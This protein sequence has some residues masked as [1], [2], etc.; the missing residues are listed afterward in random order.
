MRQKNIGNHKVVKGDLNLNNRRI[1]NGFEKQDNKVLNEFYQRNLPV[2]QRLV[3]ENSGVVE[4]AEDLMQ[5]AMMRL[6]QKIKSDVLELRCSIHTFFYGI[7]K[8]LWYNALRKNK[9]LVNFAELFENEQEEASSV[10]SILEKEDK[11]SVYQHHFSKLN[12]RSK[13][14]WELS[15]QGKSNKEIAK[16]LKCSEGS[17]RK[18]KFDAKNSLI[19]SLQKDKRYLE[20]I[21]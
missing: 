21:A 5:D 14:V 8:N 20:L 4:D 6:H 11:N 9:R 16:D 19:S 3:I 12:E 10:F 13:Y 17:I 18:R 1:I 15:F 7:C 2:I